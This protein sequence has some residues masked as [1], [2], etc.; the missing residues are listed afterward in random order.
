MAL[1]F[2]NSVLYFSYFFSYSKRFSKQRTKIGPLLD[3]K[4]KLQQHPKKM[5]DML[6]DQY[7]SVFNDVTEPPETNQ[8]PDQT[9]PT[10]DDITFTREDVTKAIKEV[11]E[12][13]ASADDDVPSVILKN[14]AEE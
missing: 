6:Q 1:S 12:Y 3:S 10:M 4:G 11:G 9:A 5:A 13:S 7:A 14:C 2:D 8:S